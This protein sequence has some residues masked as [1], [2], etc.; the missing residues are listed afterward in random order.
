MPCPGKARF[1]NK[2]DLATIV[3]IKFDDKR[4]DMTC[5]D[6]RFAKKKN[7]WPHEHLFMDMFGK[8]FSKEQK[9]VEQHTDDRET[10]H[11][12]DL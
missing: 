10:N 6:V 2:K 12:D 7:K 8:K 5:R 9:A 1:K 4:S 3:H 11:R